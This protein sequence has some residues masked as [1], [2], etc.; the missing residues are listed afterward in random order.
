VLIDDASMH[1]VW[2]SASGLV[3]ATLT[4]IVAPFLRQRW[5]RANASA[6]ESA[7]IEVARMDAS[8]KFQ[9]R[10]LERIRD[11]EQRNNG[12]CESVSTLATSIDHLSA[13]LVAAAGKMSA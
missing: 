4:M 10:L 5:Q 1:A 11:L 13:A 3:T 2:A 6:K 12:L 7:T 9:E 8:D